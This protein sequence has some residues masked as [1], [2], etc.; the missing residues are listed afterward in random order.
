MWLNQT[1]RE[2]GAMITRQYSLQ[3]RLVL[4]SQSTTS[5][6]FFCIFWLLSLTLD[7]CPSCEGS[8]AIVCKLFVFE[9]LCPGIILFS[10]L[11]LPLQSQLFQAPTELHAVVSDEKE[12]RWQKKDT[13]TTTKLSSF[14]SAAW[15]KVQL[16][17]RW[18]RRRKTSDETRRTNEK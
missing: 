11:S 12:P 4:Q 8:T 1:A 9:P 16:R 14:Q 5:L 18:R 10:F 15:Q 3:P 17:R 2:C 13:E 7:P 6:L